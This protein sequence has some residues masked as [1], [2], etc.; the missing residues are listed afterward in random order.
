MPTDS[1]K[2]VPYDSRWPLA[3]DAEAARLHR[4]LGALALRI[5]HNGASGAVSRIESGPIS[6]R[7]H[8]RCSR[9]SSVTAASRG[10]AISARGA[11]GF[12]WIQFVDGDCEPG[13]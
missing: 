1:I 8:A 2:I 4:A 3:F 7:R 13:F 5:E 6:H 11:S 12:S 9:S 10:S